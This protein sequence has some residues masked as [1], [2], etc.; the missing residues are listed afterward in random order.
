LPG[1][2]NPDCSDTVQSSEHAPRFADRSSGTETICI[3]PFFGKPYAATLVLCRIFRQK[4]QKTA[5]G[6]EDHQPGRHGSPE[7]MVLA[8]NNEIPFGLSSAQVCYSVY[9]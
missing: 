4:M 3:I 9:I 8:K 6:A 7:T 5:A 2:H 1:A